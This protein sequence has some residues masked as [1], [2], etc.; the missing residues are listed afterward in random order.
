MVLP[1]HALRA[2]QVRLKSVSNEGHFLL[3]TKQFFVRISSHIAVGWWKYSTWHSLS[4]CYAQCKLS[5][6]W[7]AM[8]GTLL[9]RLKG[10]YCPYLCWHCCGVTELCH[11]ALLSHALQCMQFRLTSF[12][13]EG[14]FTLEAKQFFVRISA[15]IAVG[16]LKYATLSSL[17]MRY[18]PW[19]LGRSRSVLKGTLLLRPKHFFIPSPLAWQWSNC[20]MPHGTPWACVTCSAS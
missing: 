4:I 1:A 10:V 2:V 19:M 13:N 12:S 9:L 5:C 3:R 6:N 8:K 14:Q 16:W 11:M 18:K 15:R 17:S 20:K 7:S